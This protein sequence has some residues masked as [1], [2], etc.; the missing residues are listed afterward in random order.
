MTPHRRPR[1][2]SSI[3][4]FRR[5]AVRVGIAVAAIGLAIGG[6]AEAKILLVGPDQAF[7]RPSE[8]IAAAGDGD[9]V[10]IAP[11]EYFDCAVVNQN[12]L[13][14]AG[15]GPDVV[16]TDKTC[17]GKALLVTRGRDITIRN[18]TLTRARVPDG[19]GAGI[20]AEGINLTIEQARFVNDEDGVL[21]ND[22]P[23]STIRIL[24]STFDHNGRCDATCAHGVYVGHIAVLRIERSTFTETM[25]G[26]HVKS[27]AGRTE[28]ID[29]DIADGPKGTSSYLVEVPEG[30]AL[31][32]RNVRLEK[33]PLSSNLRA[34]VMVGD[35]DGA[36]PTEL[37]FSHNHLKNDTGQSVAFVTNWTGASATLDANTFEGDVTDIT[38][39]GSLRH[40][41]GSEFRWIKAKIRQIGS[42]A[43]RELKSLRQ[44]MVLIA[45]L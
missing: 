26:N 5:S 11:G 33:G 36:A 27:L 28:L 45:T 24:D 40:W 6:P 30:A 2:V 15:T 35:G 43:K 9:T 29:D 16:L 32:M 21:A 42:A 14:I 8:A 23:E 34:A 39:R 20:R 7:K 4:P 44:Q 38:S 17:D 12:Q 13:V 1:P 25:A 37:A 18:L 22:A 19:N 41:A 3:P 31:V 10:E